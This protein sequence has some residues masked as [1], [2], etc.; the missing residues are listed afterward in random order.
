MASAQ[1]MGARDSSLGSF[2]RGALHRTTLPRL[3]IRGTVRVRSGA[4]PAV[5][6]HRFHFLSDLKPRAFQSYES[7]PSVRT[8][9]SMN[10]YNLPLMR[11]CFLFLI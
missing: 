9:G 3:G 1:R 2:L 5:P 4:E 7:R 10:W 6:E 8:S 11:F